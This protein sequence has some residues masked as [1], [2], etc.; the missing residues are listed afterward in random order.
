M[1]LRMVTLDELTIED[2][3]SVAHVELY[4]RLKQALRRSDHRFL[5]PDDRD[6]ACSWDRVLFL[7]LTFWSGEPSLVGPGSDDQGH[8]DDVSA[9]ADV[10]CDAHIT[11]DEL[12]HVAW[13]HVVG[14]AL[15]RELVGSTG[16]RSAEALFFCESIASAF[17]LYLVGRL[18]PNRP[19]SDFVTTQVPLMAA[20]AMDAGMSEA[21]FAALLEAICREPERAFED[22]R[23]LLLDVSNELL[24]C[25]GPIEADRALSHFVGHRFE[26]LL[27]HFE[28]SNWILY[29]RAYGARSPGR[30]AVIGRLD[31]TLRRAPDA[32]AWL[33][34]HFIDAAESKAAPTDE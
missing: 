24:G 17:D 31:A 30:D 21:R 10:L 12:S 22:M 18:L 19:D 1:A 23:A 29:A 5:V 9:A 2:E 7:N 6:R 28:L 25:V 16:P 8:R 3:G 26:P 13:H 14:R 11:A 32:L 4:G 34:D 20:R 33:S 27:H 15:A